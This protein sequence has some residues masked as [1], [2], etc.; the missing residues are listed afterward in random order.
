MKTKPKRKLKQ[1]K[2]DILMLLYKFR[3]L[4]RIQIQTLLNHKKFN[5]IIIW[6]NELAKDK[7]IIREYKRT[8]DAKPAVY[9][10]GT[11]GREELI[12]KENINQSLLK[13]VYQEKRASLIFKNHCIIIADIYISL[14][15]LAKEHNAQLKFF[16]KTDLTDIKYLILPHPDAYFSIEQKEITKRYF[17]EVFDEYPSGKWLYKRVQQY[18]YYYSQNFWQDRNTNP[19]PEIIFVYHD[20]DTK[21]DLERMIKR[22]LEDEENISFSLIS[23]EQIRLNGLRKDTLYKIE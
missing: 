9:F 17:L 18:F 11:S 16:T 7:Y 19:F 4:N 12:G 1:K 8:I 3:F 22:R 21:K 15:Q 13:R 6:L 10:L 2:I 23:W 20:P 14:V 5:R